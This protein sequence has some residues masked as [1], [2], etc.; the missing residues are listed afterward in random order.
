ML[1]VFFL[2]CSSVVGYSQTDIDAI[3]MSKNNFCA[4]FMYSH[5]SWNNYWEGTFKRDNQNLGTVSSQ[6]IGIMGNYGLKDNLNLLFSIPYVSTKASQGSLVG[7]KGL[8]D[9][10]LTVKWMPI[11]KTWGKGDFS[12]Y[13]LGSVS[14]P[15]TNYVADYLPL[16]IG[17]KSNTALVR[18]MMDYQIK[19][20]FVTASAAYVLRDKVE[21]DRAAY[22]TTQMNYTNLV[23]M[24]SVTNY[25]LRTGYRSSKLIAEAV[26]DIMHTN[27]G[28]DITKNNMPFLSNQMNATRAGVNVK[29]TLSN[30]EELSFIGNAMY[31]LMGRN[32][33]QTT[34]LSAGL[35]YV[36]DFTKKQKATNNNEEK[37]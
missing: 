30:A 37:K 2:V 32:I 20:F 3:M 6:M 18:L 5:N 27:G 16:S 21:I 24:P 11:E 19:H 28:Y 17:M 22:Y 15:T 10:T 8:Q 4:G 13:T 14:A 29:Y 7:Q 1:P 23:D 31:T 12:L 25:N 33:G 35:F 9:L 26:L 36:L 34:S